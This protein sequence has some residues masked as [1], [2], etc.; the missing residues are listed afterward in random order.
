RAVE[1]A[2]DELLA[3]GYADTLTSD[4]RHVEAWGMGQ[5][6]EGKAAESRGKRPPRHQTR[7]SAAPVRRQFSATRLWADDGLLPAGLVA[8]LPDD[9]V[10]R[11]AFTDDYGP[12]VA[13]GGLTLDEVVV[14]FISITN[15]E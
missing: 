4:H 1:A 2:I 7:E 11:R 15:Q 12:V 9:A 5:P 13:H 8:L 14:P 3:A 6:K 10:S